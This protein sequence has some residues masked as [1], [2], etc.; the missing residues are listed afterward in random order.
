MSGIESHGFEAMLLRWAETSNGGA[1]IVLQLSDAADL[2]HFKR[3]T[4]A[5]K[6]QVGQRL[7]VGV[8]EIG[9]DEQPVA[10]A[11][12]KPKGGPLSI[13]AGQWCA[14]PQFQEW[15]NTTYPEAASVVFPEPVMVDAESTAVVFPEPVMVDAESTAVVFPE[16]VMVDAESTAAV[17]RELCGVLSRAELD[18]DPHAR[19]RFDHLIRIPYRDFLEREGRQQHI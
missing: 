11:A 17:V 18:H 12:G 13:L 2:E 16:P 5:K 8:A 7:M 4:L 6:G 9:D 3:M 1:T 14:D 10:P 19:A 15:L